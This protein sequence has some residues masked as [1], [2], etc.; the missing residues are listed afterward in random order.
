MK[1]KFLFCSVF[2]VGF[3]ILCC[4]NL[5]AENIDP[6]E[7]DSQYAYGENVGWLNFEPSEGNGVHVSEAQLTGY[8]WAENIGWMSLS[9][10]NTS[11]CGTVDYGVTNDGAGNLAGYAWAE[12][13]GWISFSCENT[14][15]CGAV[16][17]GVTIDADDG[18]LHGYAWGDGNFVDDWLDSD[19]GLPGDLTGDNDVNFPD[20]SM[21]A[22]FWLSY[23]PDDWPLK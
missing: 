11:S 9:C 20:Y 13:V 1:T 7:D 3:L 22:L 21:F 14:V 19:I 10:E 17:Y 23:C 15:S 8:V 12:N 6:Y 18:E 16:D 4:G 2:L 5:H